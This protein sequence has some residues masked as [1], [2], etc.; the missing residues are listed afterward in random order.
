MNVS[1]RSLRAELG[2]GRNPHSACRARLTKLSSL[3]GLAEGAYARIQ[4]CRLWSNSGYKDSVVL[5]LF[6]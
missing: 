6:T 2:L 4:Q 1:E 5:H 3:G